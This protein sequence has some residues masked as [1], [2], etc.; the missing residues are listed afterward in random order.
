MTE[1]RPATSA[2]A[3]F[4][5]ELI[6]R[7][8]LIASGV[9]GLYGRGPAFERIRHGFDALVTRE[10]EADGAE[11]L[12]F[13]PLLPRRHLEAIGYLSSFP[14]LA[15]SVFGF[16]GSE[17]EAVA[18][19]ER[20]GRHED[21]SAS[22]RMTELALVPAACYPVYP[23]VAARGPLERA[24]IVVDA[25]GGWVFRHEPSD[26]PARLQV[27]HQREIVRLGP[28]AAVLA[29]RDGWCERGVA[30]L[31]GLG[32]DAEY[33]TA[34][35]PFFG[36]AGRMLASNQKE[37]QLKFELLVPIAGDEPTAVASFN[38]H[39]EH[40]A[41]IFGLTLADG[42][43]VHTACLGFGHERVVLALLRVHGLDPAAWPAEVARA[44]WEG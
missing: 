5:D 4:R 34:S 30:L 38:Y 19:A 36:R 27:F 33:D 20:A 22:Q 18:Q 25:G 13:P 29:W 35:D 23:A 9:P 21:W 40:F 26:D 37:Q 32:L 2:E 1:V 16:E 31:R 8:L 17:A 28:P 42:G 7:G 12:S 43:P 15:G 10:A 44:L 6:A 24:G 39:H 3:S 41:E 14:H 11:S